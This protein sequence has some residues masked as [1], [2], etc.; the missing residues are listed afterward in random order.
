M[1]VMLVY[2]HFLDARIDP[3]DIRHPPIGLHYVGAALAAAGHTVDILNRYERPDLGRWA[4][5]LRTRR[6]QVIGFSILHANRWGGIELAR[7]AKQVDPAVVIVF[8]GVGATHLWQHLLGH[9]PEIDW[10][11]RGEGEA[12]FPALLECLARGDAAAASDIPGLAR[13]VSGR[14]TAT[15]DPRPLCDLDALPMPARHF[16]LPHLSLTRG[17]VS[18]C[19]FCGSPALWGRRVRVHSADY[20]VEQLTLLRR[21][22][23]R[24]FYVSDDTFTLDRARVL[25]ACREIVR[26]GLDIEWAAISR[27]DAVDEEVLAWM[28]RAGCIQVS[29][30]VESGSAAV[31]RR[32][33]KRL[34][35]PRVRRAF[36]LTQRYGLM[37]RAYFIYG[38][39][40]ESDA[41]IAETIDLMRAIRPLG[42]VFYILDL[43][44]GTA[45]YEEFKRRTGA[46]DDIWRSR[47]EDILYFETDPALTADQVLEYGRRLRSAFYGGLPDAVAALDPVDDPELYPLHADFFSRLA[48]TFDQGDYSRIE[49]VPDKD[50]LAESLYRR[51]LGYHPDRRAVLGLGILL[52]RQRRY[53]ESLQVLRPGVEHHSH[54]P[55][56]AV[57]L[58]VTL[59]NLD[60]GA[61]ALQ[62]LRR[63]P[64]HPGA[65]ELTRSAGAG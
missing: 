55:E 33:N 21:R 47:V 49:L 29:Y 64:E 6:P 19:A 58:A 59:L 52:Q 24:F 51:A 38:C 62:L 25:A 63:F 10:V 50:R 1:N 30:G 15:S 61:E 56:L 9:F 34:S 48:L 13:R 12:S 37:A 17:C 54:D 44:P 42:A 39:P 8:G 14:P 57:C 16:D 32:L 3:E 45:L 23:R 53:P 31:R 20:F 4:E 60:R 11:V 46:T 40:G 18:N 35:V 28:R 27:V 43:F 65:R 26:R 41:T 5:E 22:G 2:P 7:V 36:E